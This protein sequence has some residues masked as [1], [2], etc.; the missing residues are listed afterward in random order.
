M[1]KYLFVYAL[2][3]CTLVGCKDNSG[4]YS[5]L[6]DYDFRIAEL[7]QICNK[8]NTNIEALQ[9]IVEA[10]QTGDYITGIT[11][12]MESGVEIGYTITFAKHE[13]IT[14]YHGKN[15]ADGKDGQNGQDGD[16][17]FQSVTQD[18]DSVYFLMTD[19]TLISISKRI[20][21]YGT[22]PE[23][24]VDIEG[25]AIKAA[26][27]VSATKKVYFSQGNLQYQASTNTWRFANQQYHMIGVTNDN[28]SDSF[29]GWI[30]LFGYG[31]SGYNSKMPYQASTINSDY[32]SGNITN[33]DYD[34]GKYN[35]ISN[36]GS[37]SNQW[38]TLTIEEW[39]YLLSRES[40]CSVATVNN[41]RG[42]ILLPDVWTLPEGITF[43][44]QATE[45]STNVY[46]YLDWKEMESA[47]AIFLPAAGSRSGTIFASYVMGYTTGVKCV[48]LLLVI[49]C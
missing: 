6:N 45:Y 16:S 21:G 18:E 5:L 19:G 41:V 4:L 48:W 33:T 20:K 43:T 36:G 9:V 11:P 44:A 35:S 39:N 38:R 3:L 14:I 2:A 28:I 29:S 23:N 49:K 47:G 27:S 26:F 17:M 30:D 40:R 42:Y 34:W 25:G 46:S 24:T 15:G 12:I 31:T 13:P 1:K 37:V 10:Q 8:L 7:E 22:L 32:F